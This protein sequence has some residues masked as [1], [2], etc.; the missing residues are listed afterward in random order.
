MSAKTALGQ[1]GQEILSWVGRWVLAPLNEAGQTVF[2]CVAALLHGQSLWD[3]RD[4]FLTQLRIC[5]MGGMP[6]TMLV[7]GFSGMILAYQTGLQLRELGQ[8]STVGILVMVGMCREMGPVMTGLALSGLI[9]SK[10]A[11]E[12]GAMRV[13]EE[14]DALEVMSI[15]PVKYLVMPR[16]FAM[17]LAAPAL[18]LLADVAGIWA[19]GVITQ[20]KFDVNPTVYY[21]NGRDWLRDKDIW[22]GLLKSV[23]FG[24]LISVVGCRC[25]LRAAGGASGVGI[26][27]MRA[28]VI[29]CVFVV[30]LDLVLNMRIWP[31]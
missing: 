10:M 16:V 28:V 21:G 22:G 8:E 17:I 15:S 19:G 6:V 23:V 20:I 7:A 12:I 14:L 9:A 2:L 25:G 29:S 27:T 18:T 5:A 4:E 1:L 3:K 24:V 26:A 31:E 13:S 30:V 11:A